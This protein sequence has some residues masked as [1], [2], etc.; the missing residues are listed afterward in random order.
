MMKKETRKLIDE[1]LADPNRLLQK[2]PFTRGTDIEYGP[3]DHSSVGI[4]EMVPARLPKCKVVVVPQEQYM[5]ELEPS[6][7]SVLFDDNIPSITMKLKNGGYMDIKYEKSALPIQKLIKNKQVLHL[8]GHKMDF[9]L[10]DSDPAESVQKDFVLIKQYWEKRNMDGLKNK[11]VDTQKSYGD[12]GLLFYFDY[13]GRIKARILSF[14][15]GYILCPHNDDN[16]DRILESVYYKSGNVEYIDSYDDVYMYRYSNDG[17]TYNES[18]GWRWHDPVRHGFNEIPLVTKRGK[19]AWDDVQ[20]LI[21]SKEV[22]FNI[23]NVIQKRHGWGML[24][25]KGK[26]KD[27]AKKIAGSVI[28]ND[29]SIDGNG[30]AKYL[31]PPSPEGTIDTLNALDEEIQKGSSTT[32]L[33]PKD[34]KAQGDVSGIA[35][36]LTQSMDIE[37]A[38]RGVI[39]WQNV[40]DKMCRL[41]KYG[42]AMELVDNGTKPNAIT[43]FEKVNM[44]AKFKVWRPFNDYE[45]NQMVAT[46]TTNGI[47]SKET[48]VEVNTLSRPDEL[49][50]IRRQEEEA[51]RAAKETAMEQAKVAAAA[52]EKQEQE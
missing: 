29:T 23:F 31:T 48:G 46:L 30:D 39:D 14:A 9:T 10:L 5:R 17:V 11:M 49:V 12:A 24:Y 40:A 22:L 51:A 32:F 28:L 43:E 33:L 16:G 15:D 52:T 34:I 45:Y 7:H 25:I 21:E 8:T 20:S 44:V 37:N 47:L 6:S 36:Q 1:L 41:F 26:F 42:L 4:T 38:L 18:G 50:R 13:M 2:K 27:D 19:V 35:V 3:S